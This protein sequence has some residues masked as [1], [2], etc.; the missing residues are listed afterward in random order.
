MHNLGKKEDLQFHLKKSEK[1]EQKWKK[2][3]NKD[4]SRNQL[5]RKET[6]NRKN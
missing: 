1:Q 5:H 3:I 6:D 4:K 2:V